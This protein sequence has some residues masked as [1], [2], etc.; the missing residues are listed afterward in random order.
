[1]RDR[2]GLL[3]TLDPEDFTPEG[4]LGGSTLKNVIYNKYADDRMF[5]TQRPSIRMSVDASETIVD[6]KG[7]GVYYWERTSSLYMVNN[8]TI[9]EDSYSNIVGL[10]SEGVDPVTILEIGI[11]LVFLDTANN[12]GW[13]LTDSG[14]L[15]EITD[16]DF[17]NF[18]AGGGAVLNSTLYVMDT[19]GVIYASGINDPANWAALDVL[20]AEREPD[21]GRYLSKIGDHI[22]A[23]GTRTIEFFYDAANPV[24]SPLSRREDI[25]YRGYGALD[26]YSFYNTGDSIYYLSSDITG[27]ISLTM[28][29]DF[30]NETVSTPQIDAYLNKVVITDNNRFVLS[31]AMTD[32]HKLIFLTEVESN[33]S[34]L[35]PTIT[36]VLDHSI[37]TWSIFETTMKGHTY[38]PVVQWSDRVKGDVR[39]G[40]GILYNGDIVRFNPTDVVL[41]V[42][43]QD[44]YVAEGYWTDG[45]VEDLTASASTEVEMLIRTTEY[46][47]QGDSVYNNKF[48]NKLELLGGVNQGLE[49]EGEF[50]YIRWTDDHYNKYT[51]YKKL[52][53]VPGRKMGALGRFN[54]RA[55]ELSYSG[56]KRLRL[57]GLEVMYGVSSYA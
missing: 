49:Y 13:V 43:L 19:D 33:S 32:G 51:P 47:G 14:S 5:A 23:F 54:R 25:S 39:L 18:L 31:G 4:L 44:S 22:V 16:E 38:F 24:G 10:I 45:Y 52:S 53:L 1:M 3:T 34:N 6:D 20:S 41:D 50:V 57:E 37:G 35:A 40:A 2:I 21:S 30:R 46:G 26:F 48:M 9:Y 42:F 28:L 17:P 8:G 29:R 12:Q 7:R 15:T 56:S 11:Y 36:L 27:S 55:F